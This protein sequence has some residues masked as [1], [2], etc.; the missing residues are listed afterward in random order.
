[1][2]ICALDELDVC[3]GC[4]RTVDEITGWGRMDNTARRAVLALCE[5]RALKSGKFLIPPRRGL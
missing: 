4:Q 3:V 1:M 2:S 5:E